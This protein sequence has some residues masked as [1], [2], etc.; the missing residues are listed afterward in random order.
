MKVLVTGGAGFIASHL[1]DSLISQGHDVVIID[2]LST[3]KRENVNS[4]AAFFEEDICNTE[5]L[6][7]IFSKEKPDIVNHHAAQIDLRKSVREPLYDAQINILG[8]LNLINLSNKYNVKKIIY[9]STGGAVYGEPKYLP[10]DEKH[11]INPQS[12][13]GVSKHTVELY[14]FAFKQTHN[15][16]YAVLRYPNVYGP[17]QDPHGEAGVVAIFT[18][19]M[20]DGKQPTIFGDGTKTRDYVYVDDIIDANMNVMFKSVSS[21]DEIYNIGWGK[22]IK[23]IEIFESVRDALG[24]YVKPIY[25]KKRQGEIDHI[26]L[27]STKAVKGLGWKPKV[28]LQDGIRLTTNFYK[29]RRQTI[30]GTLEQD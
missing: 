12:Q 15:L 18:E 19:Q 14:L 24:L 22:E 5:S 17:R 20:L 11:L 9:I 6:E 10:V 30:D 28:E 3:G 26:C 21:H 7:K 25:D 23:D 1:V 8:S 16:D 2:N 13:Y 4:K 27:D 29:E